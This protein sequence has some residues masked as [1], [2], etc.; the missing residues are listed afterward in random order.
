MLHVAWQP[1]FDF[2]LLQQPMADA[3]DDLTELTDFSTSKVARA[4]LDRWQNGDIFT[5]IHP[6]T[7]VYLH[8][9][10]ASSQL[11]S[12]SYI[13]AYMS[14]DMA[15]YAERLP[16]HI[17]DLLERALLETSD[18]P[19]VIFN[20]G[21]FAAGQSVLV[22]RMLEY[23][24]ARSDLHRKSNTGAAAAQSARAV[25][26]ERLTAVSDIMG[27]FCSDADIAD[28]SYAGQ[29]I[30]LAFDQFGVL[31][32]AKV[33]ALLLDARPVSTNGFPML[34][35]LH[36]GL[37]DKEQFPLLLHL[38]RDTEENRECRAG[39]LKIQSA[40]DALNV[41]RQTQQDLYGFL[42][43]IIFLRM[44]SLPL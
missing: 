3:V 12:E 30:Q 27:A 5:S 4:L 44:P 31:A 6:P 29:A 40:L 15:N 41:T 21:S 14:A 22:Q 36:N 16:P 9:S 23:C 19:Q 1:T 24:A 25:D 2:K 35:F 33:R 20:V 11:Y 7:L 26:L 42:V 17:Y 13:E 43:A 37:T 34:R 28:V 39:F 8:D 38:R 32:G 10:S 18:K